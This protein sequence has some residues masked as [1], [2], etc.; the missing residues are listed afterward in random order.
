MPNGEEIL[1]SGMNCLPQT[2]YEDEFTQLERGDDGSSAEFGQVVFVGASDFLYQTVQ[3]HALE[4][5]R[6]LGGGLFGQQ[7]SQVFVGEAVEVELA[8]DDGQEEAPVVVSQEVKTGEG[9][10][11]V[12]FG[13]GYLVDVLEA[14][15]GVFDLGDEVQVAAVGGVAQVDQGGKTVN[16]LAQRRLLASAGAVAVFYLA[17][18]LEQSAHR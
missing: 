6:D 2:R 14:Y 18:V 17:V 9:A 11:V 4:Q 1:T 7:A 13:F 10:I 5:A 16:G 8:A 3:A 15:T 12:A